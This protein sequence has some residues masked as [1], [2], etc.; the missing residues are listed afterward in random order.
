MLTASRTQN[1]FMVVFRNKP[2]LKSGH[3]R[4]LSLRHRVCHFDSNHIRAPEM[5]L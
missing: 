1:A 3:G 2:D 5:L 4:R